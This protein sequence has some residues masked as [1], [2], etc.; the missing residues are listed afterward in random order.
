MYA[1]LFSLNLKLLKLYMPW[2]E[3]ECEKERPLCGILHAHIKL[4]FSKHVRCTRSDA[5]TF[6]FPIQL[7][8]KTEWMN[9]SVRFQ[10]S[11]HLAF[12]AL[13]IMNKRE[14]KMWNLFGSENKK[15]RSWNKIHLLAAQ[16]HHE[17]C[18]VYHTHRHTYTPIYFHSNNFS[19]YCICKTP[20]AIV[21]LW[22]CFPLKTY[23]FKA[24]CVLM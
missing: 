22:I 6:F 19:A 10:L 12:T 21:I 18:T 8:K 13:M 15:K 5:S 23:N 7:K 17:L 1:D 3:N 24:F 11:I 20:T 16:P 14:K 4:P 9:E 2:E